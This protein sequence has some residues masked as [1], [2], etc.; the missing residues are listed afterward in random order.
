MATTGARITL[1]KYGIID[2]R[3]MFSMAVLLAELETAL[4]EIR[5]RRTW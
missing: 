1:L 5:S 4:K 2:P 3:P